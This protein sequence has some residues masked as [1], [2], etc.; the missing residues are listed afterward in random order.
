M[1][2]YLKVSLTLATIASGSAL[3]IGLMNLATVNP[4]NTNKANRIKNGL[5]E[6]YPNLTSYSAHDF[7]EEGEEGFEAQYSATAFPCIKTLYL[8][9]TNASA[10]GYVYSTTGKNSYGQVNLLFSVNEGKVGEIFVVT[11]T[12]TYG[13]TLEENYVD[14]YNYGLLENGLADVKCGATFGAKTV[15]QQCDE[16]IEHWNLYY[17]EGAE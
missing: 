4:I 17:G 13:Q 2:K 3:L 6:L 1:N 16:A 9:D 7:L 10:R 12:E 14:L 11:N 15:K 5:A 8:V